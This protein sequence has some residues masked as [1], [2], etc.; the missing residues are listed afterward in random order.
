[1]PIYEFRCTECY[2]V[3]EEMLSF[4][5]NQKTI[6]CPVC[7]NRSE[8]IVS[9]GSFQL[10]G[11]GWC[12]DGYEK[13]PGDPGHRLQHLKLNKR[14]KIQDDPDKPFRGI[15]PGFKPEYNRNPNPNLDKYGERIVD[16]EKITVTSKKKK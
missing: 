14:G 2:E 9:L 8:K 11:G 15:K 7:G 16:R 3:S 12:K 5:S 4:K 13:K 1:M 6:N 10:K